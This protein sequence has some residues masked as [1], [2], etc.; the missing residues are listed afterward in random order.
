M[1]DAW[2]MLADMDPQLREDVLDLASDTGIDLVAL[3]VN[4][5]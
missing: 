3:L 2:R 1:A 5:D 4:E